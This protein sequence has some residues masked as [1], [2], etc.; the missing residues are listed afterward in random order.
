MKLKE[1]EA[2]QEEPNYAAR[3]AYAVGA[4]LLAM[5]IMIMMMD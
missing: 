1:M 3:F 2:T 5:A 4:I